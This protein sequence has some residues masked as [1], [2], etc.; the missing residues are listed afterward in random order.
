MPCEVSRTF[1]AIVML[2]LVG[3]LLLTLRGVRLQLWDT[4]GTWPASL[5]CHLLANL[6]ISM[7]LCGTAS[8]SAVCRHCPEGIAS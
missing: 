3:C 7:Y 4:T 6:G 8:L 1:A 2:P 5:H